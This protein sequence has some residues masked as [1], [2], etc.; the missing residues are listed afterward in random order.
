MRHDDWRPVRHWCT[1]SVGLWVADCLRAYPAVI[2][3]MASPSPEEQADT[4]AAA[5]FVDIEGSIVRAL[6]DALAGNDA[7][8]RWIAGSTVAVNVAGPQP[9][10]VLAAVRP[11]T[12]L[13]ASLTHIVHHSSHAM[14]SC[15]ED[16][17]DELT[18]PVDLSAAPSTAVA[19]LAA[20]V[21]STARSTV[22]LLAALPSSTTLS[23]Q[24]IAS[25]C[26]CAA[27]RAPSTAALS[28]PAAQVAR[29]QA[30][31]LPWQR[32]QPALLLASAAAF[33]AASQEEPQAVLE[34]LGL[35]LASTADLRVFRCALRFGLALV[36]ADTCALLQGT[37]PPTTD[38]TPS[39]M[40]LDMTR[41][42]AHSQRL[43]RAAAEAPG[44][45]RQPIRL[46]GLRLPAA[47]KTCLELPGPEQAWT[48]QLALRGLC[49]QQGWAWT[50]REALSSHVWP[51]LT[52]AVDALLAL[53]AGEAAEG[54][55]TSTLAGT[56]EQCAGGVVNPHV[57]AGAMWPR[58]TQLHSCRHACHILDCAF[59]IVRDAIGAACT[60]S[61]AASVLRGATNLLARVV[62][63]L[64]SAVATPV[65]PTEASAHLPVSVA[66]PLAL[67]LMEPIE[68]VP[69]CPLP[70]FVLLRMAVGVAEVWQAFKQS[71][72][73]APLV[74]LSL[75]HPLKEGAPRPS[76]VRGV[77]DYEWEACRKAYATLRQSVWGAV[78][79]AVALP[80][81]LQVQL[82]PLLCTISL[83][84]PRGAQGKA[85]DARP[86]A[87]QPLVPGPGSGRRTGGSKRRAEGSREQPK[88]KKR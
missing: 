82:P 17:V 55:D 16:A 78:D 34:M 20:S 26:L 75:G 24:P 40:L 74:A 27:A 76:S 85:T 22:A 4:E 21:Q 64:R 11:P 38:S 7:A 49:L 15:P 84:P 44:K 86:A 58:Q 62:G 54:D 65:Q 36:S 69:T 80:G 41:R 43:N 3:C 23:L 29:N 88:S 50:Y 70:P 39:H 10:Q 51:A 59:G 53:P 77:T 19:D 66:D 12:L 9:K 68:D 31:S 63:T 1:W 56:W 81:P 60:A 13:H 48:A 6:H 2:A 14:R 30:A 45:S 8:R 67:P 25:A 28:S 18:G 83:P 33:L 42:L 57:W 32:L 71:S 73:A 87:V 5:Q 52:A 72:V 35:V 61:V 46:A 47:V 79:W 37:S